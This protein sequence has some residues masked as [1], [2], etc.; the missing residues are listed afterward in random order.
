MRSVLAERADAAGGEDGA[1]LLAGNLQDVDEAVHLDVPGQQG[2]RLGNGREQGG[3]VID[4]VDLVLVH[5]RSQLGGVGHVGLL[6]R[7]AFQQDAL[8]LAAFDVTGDN[9]GVGDFSTQFH[10]EL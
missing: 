8:R 7:A 6:C 9:G 10:S 3:E 4:G 2:L 5:N 1:V